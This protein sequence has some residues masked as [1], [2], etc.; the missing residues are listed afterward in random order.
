MTGA[1][2]IPFLHNFE[3]LTLQFAAI[4]QSLSFP[5]PPSPPG[6]KLPILSLLFD[7]FQPHDHCDHH[8]IHV[9]AAMPVPTIGCAL[10][11]KTGIIIFRCQL[12]W[13][14]TLTKDRNCY[15]DCEKTRPPTMFACL[16][17]GLYLKGLGHEM[18]SF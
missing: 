11:Q 2:I 1:S 5:L 8:P 17:S 15:F 10:L 14:R 7:P 18:N 4:P 16:W 13:L 12:Y 9:D 6:R 3:L